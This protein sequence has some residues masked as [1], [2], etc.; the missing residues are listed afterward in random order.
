MN[1]SRHASADRIIEEVHRFVEGF[2]GHVR[3]AIGEGLLGEDDGLR[4]EDEVD[5]ALRVGL[6]HGLAGRR[7]LMDANRL[8]GDTKSFLRFAPIL[9][10]TRQRCYLFLTRTYPPGSL[11]G[12]G[13]YI[14]QLARALAALGHQIHVATA[15]EGHDRVDFEDGVWVHRIVP[16]DFPTPSPEVL[17]ALYPSTSGIIHALC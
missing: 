1:G 9:P 2:R 17:G 3:W 6:A 14:H 8:T 13:R 5:R 11:G 10:A 4:F 15:G 7:Q 16:R 12:I